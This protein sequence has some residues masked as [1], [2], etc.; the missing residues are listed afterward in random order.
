ME[1]SEGSDHIVSCSVGREKPL[2]GYDGLNFKQLSVKPKFR[3]Q[4]GIR[5]PEKRL[6][7][8]SSKS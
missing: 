7:Q 8:W 5:K 3:G 1:G 2:V 6:P 4:S